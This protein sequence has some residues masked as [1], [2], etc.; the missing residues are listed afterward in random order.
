M[1]WSQSVNAAE[2]DWINC[3]GLDPAKWRY[4]MPDGTKFFIY[5]FG[6]GNE[7]GQTIF[8]MVGRARPNNYAIE[9]ARFPAEDHESAFTS[10]RGSRTVEW[11]ERLQARWLPPVR[12][13]FIGGSTPEEATR[14]AV[15]NLAEEFGTTLYRFTNLSN[16]WTV[17][18]TSGLKITV[19]AHAH[20]TT[21]RRHDF[22]AHTLGNPPGML[23]LARFPKRHVRSV[24]PVKANPA[25][26]HQLS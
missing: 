12:R 17:E 1:A 16:T 3:L 7:D 22:I 20:Y 21:R 8:E 23:D 11:L 14:N 19:H 2:S 26:T 4:L 5:A 13:V 15:V 10:W 25:N 18:L 24:T 9:V 6:V